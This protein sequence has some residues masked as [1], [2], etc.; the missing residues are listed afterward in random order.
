MEELIKRIV[1]ALV[2]DPDQISV[3]KVEG[4]R[5]V[6][7][8]LSVAKED[9]GKVIGQRGRNIDSIRT[10]LAGASAKANK[11]SVLELIEEDRTRA[12]PVTSGEPLRERFRKETGVR[13][14]VVKWFNDRKGY[15]FIRMDDGE[16]V[17]VHYKSI[18]E[19]DQTLMEGDRVTFETI[20]GDKGLKAINVT[21][22]DG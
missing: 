20:E 7:Y 2:D 14:G 5:T 18:R 17:F 19:R 8:E 21:R 11:S 15:G 4:E 3:K 9:F 6:V 22:T 16:D 10:I 1:S 13:K 12:A